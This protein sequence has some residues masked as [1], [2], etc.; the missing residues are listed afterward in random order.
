MVTYQGN[1]LIVPVPR[2]TEVLVDFDSIRVYRGAGPAGPFSTLVTTIPLVAGQRSYTYQDTAGTSTSWY[3]NEYYHTVSAEVSQRSAPYP[4]SV[5]EVVTLRQLVRDVAARAGLLRPPRRQRLTPTAACGTLTT[6]SDANTIKVTEYA[7]TLFDSTHFKGAVI[8]LNDGA[9]AGQ[10]RE[11]NTFSVISGVGTF[12]MAEDFTGSPAS[13]VTID[14]YALVGTDDIRNAINAARTDI[15]VDRQAA[16]VG[17]ENTSEY[18]LP[19]YFANRSWIQN[20][21]WQSGQELPYTYTNIGVSGAIS[22]VEGRLVWRGS[23][24]ENQVLQIQGVAHPDPLE[25]MDEEVALTDDLRDYWVLCG[26]AELA[27]RIKQAMTGDDRKQWNDRFVAL[28]N[29]RKVR[30]AELGM[31]THGPNPFVQ[32]FVAVGGDPY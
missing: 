19:A 32:D 17:V 7:S 26:A 12:E 21:V 18:Q 20:I 6:G 15:W 30:A 11:I 3:E 8:H 16:I 22:A 10:E 13:G 5:G 31:R 29:E 9:L 28:E 14:I 25:S 2:I 24:A 4:A 27:Y 1:T 23:L